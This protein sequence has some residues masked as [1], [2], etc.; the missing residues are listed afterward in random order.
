MILSILLL[1][2]FIS[3]FQN[4]TSFDPLEQTYCP[5][6]QSDRLTTSP[7]TLF[8]KN[9][10]LNSTISQSPRIPNYNPNRNNFSTT[11]FNH[12]NIGIL[13]ID[14]STTKSSTAIQTLYSYSPEHQ[15]DIQIHVSKKNPTSISKEILNMIREKNVNFLAC[16]P[17]FLNPHLE[18]TNEIA[19]YVNDTIE[20]YMTQEERNTVKV[21]LADCVGDD[22]SAIIPAIEFLVDQ[23]LE[24][25]IYKVEN[26][27]KEDLVLEKELE[28][29]STVIVEK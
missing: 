16:L 17:Y 8:P 19:G 21:I 6:T 25:G 28:D 14:H 5:S 15:S 26:K 4:C 10:D 2:L 22:L 24:E 11:K 23:Q 18:I 3:I 7:P 12:T 27:N 20:E 13:L 1:L 9:I 29:G